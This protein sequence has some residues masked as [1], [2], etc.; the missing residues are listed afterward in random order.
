MRKAQL[1]Y[2]N[3]EPIWLSHVYNTVTTSLLL[4]VFK[5]ADCLTSCSE[6]MF[7]EMALCLDLVSMPWVYS[8]KKA[9]FDV[10]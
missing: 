10:L 7:F 8:P 4:C 9:I 3:N 5:M 2:I 6:M 1:S